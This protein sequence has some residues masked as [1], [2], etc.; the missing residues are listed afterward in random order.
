M[1]LVA[2]LVI[3]I[4][5]GFLFRQ[6][7][8]LYARIIIGSTLGIVFFA[9]RPFIFYYISI[10]G[11][12]DTYL[13]AFYAV[14]AL[15]VIALTALLL[16]IR[17]QLFAAGVA[18]SV[19]LVMTMFAQLYETEIKN[20]LLIHTG[21]FSEDSPL[22]PAYASSVQASYDKKKMFIY[23]RSGYTVSLHNDWQKQIDKGDM[24]D[25][26]HLVRN[27]ETVAEF[28]PKCIGKAKVPLPVI[29]KSVGDVIGSVGKTS[30]EHC[31]QV[32]K[33]NYACNVMV[34]NKALTPERIR[35]FNLN[36]QYNLGAELDFVIFKH[37]DTLMDEIGDIVRS[38]KITVVGEMRDDCL[39]TV[40]WM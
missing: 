20:N 36:T 4:L 10:Y 21:Y 13:I 3:V 7:K 29:A 33:V 6:K 15:F 30:K 9:I 38:V 2:L 40:E 32:D 22:P 35:W 19:F 11:L 17:L 8:S 25:Y 28:R 5:T 31:Y 37:S 16:G 24:F 14:V 12:S 34:F 1:Q 26:F 18:L 39:A 27:A 23:D